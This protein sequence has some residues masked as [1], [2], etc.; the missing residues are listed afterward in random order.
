MTLSR[1]RFLELTSTAAAATLLPASAQT[2]SAQTDGGKLPPSIAA[3]SRERVKPF[4]SARTRCAARV[5]RARELMATNHLQ[6][7]VVTTGSS[8]PYFSAL[9]LVDQR[10]A[11]CHGAAGERR[12]VLCVSGIRGG[13][14]A[15]AAC[16]WSL[17]AKA[18]VR[19]WQEDENPYT[20]W[21][22]DSR[23]LGLAYRSARES[24][25]RHHFV[26]SN[27]DRAEC[28]RACRLPAR[29]RSQRAAG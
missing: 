17:R 6:A 24:K 8:L 22:R 19:T 7:I 27:G 16:D 18:D 9:A 23:D 15:R 13:P 10:T 29:R 5:E 2:Q 1:R 28:F 12:S 3:S 14:R 21:R 11:V 4:R 20:R 26:F 25:R